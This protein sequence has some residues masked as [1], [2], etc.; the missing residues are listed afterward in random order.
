MM[1]MWR[2]V[3]I[4]A[5]TE[6]GSLGS[7]RKY[8]VFILKAIGVMRWMDIESVIQSEVSQKEKSKYRL[9]TQICGIQEN[10]TDEPISRAVIET[11]TWRTDMWTQ[12]GKG[13]RG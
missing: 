2:W 10:G 3:W 6:S 11:Q 12:W 1:D 9:L 13:R 4:E 7:C 8:L 5:G